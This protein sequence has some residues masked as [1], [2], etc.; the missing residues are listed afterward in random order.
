MQK[1]KKYDWKDSNLAL[2]GSDT[3]RKVKKESAEAE[4]AWQGAG[5]DVGRQIWRIVKFKV[6]EWHRDDYGTFY[7][8]DSYL[9]LNTYKKPG[10]DELLYD[11]HFWIGQ[12]STQ[13]EYG[14]AAYKTVELD[15]LLDDKPVQHREVM[16][17]ES[18]LFK[19]YFSA[20]K[21]LDGG[22]E[23]GFRHVKPEEYTPRLLHF[24]GTRKT[25]EVRQVAFSLKSLN[26]NDVFIVD[27]GLEI[28]QWNGKLSSKDEKFKASQF[29][30]QLKAERQG[31]ASVSVFDEGDSSDMRKLRKILPDEDVPEET[32][33]KEESSFTPRLLR[34]SDASGSLQFSL[35]SE[36]NLSL[37]SLDSTDVFIVDTGSAV[38][39]WVGDGASQAE[40]QN[41]LSYAHSYL[42]KSSHPLVPVT[43][44]KKGQETEEFRKAFTS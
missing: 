35:V 36:G 33:E 5:R 24:S 1:A 27:N 13:D 40:K 28:I 12:Y 16:S 2:F 22:A 17:H 37:A 31:R 7:N 25:V 11:L 21:L 26:S 9:I 32:E 4:P 29:L 10:E 30:Q 8:G 19:S 6:T 39:V 44:L 23:T 18:A 38:F 14:T 43:V 3:E 42:Q 41:G 20:I 15:T 34:L